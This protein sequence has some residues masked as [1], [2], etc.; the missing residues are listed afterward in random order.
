MDTAPA[1]SELDDRLQRDQWNA[2]FAVER[3]R[4]ALARIRPPR[5]PVDSRFGVTVHDTSRFEHHDRTRLALEAIAD[6]PFQV[7]VEVNTELAGNG[8]ASVEKEQLWYANT[9]SSANEVLT[10]GSRSV[11]VLAWTHPGLQKALSLDIGDFADLSAHGYRLLSVEPLAKARFDAVFP[12]I[13]G[14]YQPGGS[15]RPRKPIP[16][17]AGLKAVK[18]EMTRDQVSAFI[19]RMSG[20]MVV[21]G[22]PGSGKTTVAFQRIRFLYDQQGERQ[23][24][25]GLVNY[26]PG[27]T[28]VFLA[29][30]NLSD[31]A[32]TLL[33]DQLDIP[34]SVVMPVNEFVAA[35]LDQV[36]AYKHNARPRQRKLLPLETAAR[37][38]ILGLSDHLDLGR[39]WEEYERQIADR[40]GSAADSAWAREDGDKNGY[41]KALVRSFAVVGEHAEF[42]TN[43]LQSRLSMGVVFSAVQDSYS[44]ARSSMSAVSRTQFDELFQQWLYAVYDP[45][46][47]LAAYF[48][49]RRTEAAHRMRSGTGAR[50][51]EA[52]VLGGAIDEWNQ[53]RYGP[54]DR[55]WL[56]W[57]LRFALPVVTDPQRRFREIP[58]AIAPVLSNDQRWTHVVIDEA[59]DLCVAEASLIGSFVDPDGALTVSADFRQIVSPVH[60]MRSPEALHVGRSVRSRGADLQY[61]FAKNMRQSRQ[62]GQFLQSFYEAAF[63]ELP[64]FDVNETL[65]D[66]KP[67]LILAPPHD[68]A[69]R[70]KQ[71]FAVLQRLNGIDSVAVIQINEDEQSL[72]RLRSELESLD[73]ALAPIWSSSGDGLL[74]TS[75]ERIKGL[76]F[77]ACIV[78]GLE[79]VESAALNFTLNRAY[80]GLSRPTRRLALVA[81]VFPSLLRRVP[82]TLFDVTQA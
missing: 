49:N 13:S 9:N 66:R 74:T 53:R 43:P 10:G 45:L 75:V 34:A 69:L 32:K 35:Y 8:N 29:N 82:R 57:L 73:V 56:V 17:K 25:H 21:T 63:K 80:V 33:E 58:S 67:Q 65:E 22:A 52:A 46:A 24:E 54:E 48:G 39:L 50:V 30:E 11:N 15:V 23:D 38:A 2:E 64:A 37:T 78:L 51:E 12:N 5:G 41:L 31:Q 6:E 76:E 7:M 27:L 26:T 60:G 55:S 16:L 28:R 62:I 14:I 40:L 20:L 18:L 19:S 68:Q 1:R 44:K 42:G 81:E 47:A 3:A 77:D 59:Q 4:D 79:H 36:W 71:L 72:S 61:P 70:I